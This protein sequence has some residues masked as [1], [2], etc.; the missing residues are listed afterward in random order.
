LIASHKHHC[1]LAPPR[2]GD[3]HKRRAAN[4]AR[5][6][7]EE[8]SQENMLSQ[9]LHVLCILRCLNH[10]CIT[11]ICTN[12]KLIQQRM[13]FRTTTYISG[14]GTQSTHMGLLGC[15]LKAIGR[16]LTASH[17]LRKIRVMAASL[18]LAGAMLCFYWSLQR[19]M[20]RKGGLTSLH[21]HLGRWCGNFFQ[22][23]SP[24]SRGCQVEGAP[25]SQLN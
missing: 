2:L 18:H 4:I 9:L 25:P 15:G 16:P 10:V 22:P 5:G 7:R 13:S 19:P 21:R 23:L 20:A 6:H 14:G 3:L 8:L 11:N 1:H 17:I 12:Y 24:L